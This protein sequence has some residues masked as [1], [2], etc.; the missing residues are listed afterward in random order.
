MGFVPFLDSNKLSE[1]IRLLSFLCHCFHVCIIRIITLSHKVTGKYNSL[2][3]VEYP[4]ILRMVV[5]KCKIL[6]NCQLFSY[7][8]SPFCLK[9]KTIHMTRRLKTFMYNIEDCL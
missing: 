4:A 1:L 7:N 9:A 2:I 5:Q 6:L 8:I 3:C